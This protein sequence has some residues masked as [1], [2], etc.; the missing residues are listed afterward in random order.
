MTSVRVD[1]GLKGNNDRVPSGRSIFVEI[2]DEGADIF[3]LARRKRLKVGR[4]RL[5]VRVARDVFDRGAARDKYA[6]GN[7]QHGKH[8]ES[9]RGKSVDPNNPKPDKAH[10]RLRVPGT[11]YTA[12][13]NRVYG[14]PTVFQLP[15]FL[16]CTFSGCEAE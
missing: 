4:V 16:R 9:C 8:R 1:F 13:V 7:K 3:C 14:T 5:A 10:N 12:S 11:I 2:D 6:E 15:C